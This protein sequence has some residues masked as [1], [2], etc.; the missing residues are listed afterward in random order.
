MTHGEIARAIQEAYQD[1]LPLRL[2][3][4]EQGE[5]LRAALHAI[6]RQIEHL[7]LD[8]FT[9]SLL[10]DV[11]TRGRWHDPDFGKERRTIIINLLKFRLHIGEFIHDVAPAIEI[12]EAI[13][14]EQP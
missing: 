9:V 8:T 11:A 4:I 1:E 6:A 12:A 10:N 2:T 7:D 14:E 3:F 13:R 5:K